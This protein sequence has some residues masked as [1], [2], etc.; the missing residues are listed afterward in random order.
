MHRFMKRAIALANKNVEEGGQPFGAVLARGEEKISEG[1]NEMHLRHNV[2]GHAELVAIQSAQ[3]KLDADELSG[4]TMYAS[5]HP[6]P[7]CLTAMYLVGITDIY[8]F[9][10]NEEA[11]AAGLTKASEIYEDLAKSNTD[12]RIVMKKVDPEEEIQDP[13]EA[14]KEKK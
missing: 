5:G 4:L 10:S 11:V 8:Y 1:V 2:A 14:W 13:M 3:K 7:M 9:N 6:C 12:R